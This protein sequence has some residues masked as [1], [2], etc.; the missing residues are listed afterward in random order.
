MDELVQKIGK[1]LQKNPDS[2]ARHICRQI[3]VDKKIVNRCLYA[4]RKIHFLQ[5]G[6]APPLWRNIDDSFKTNSD[7]VTKKIKQNASNTTR[8]RQN[9]HL[10][11]YPSPLFAQP[12]EVGKLFGYADRTGEYLL[13]GPFSI[14]D[15]ET[16]GL[17]PSAGKIL[18]I[19]IRKVD[20]D[21]REIEQFETLI[22]PGDGNVGR[23]D[24]H[25]IDLR[26]LDGAPYFEDVVGRIF[27][28]IQDSVVVAHH[29][30]FEEN[31][32]FSE[33][34]DS[35]Y[36]LEPIPAL[37]TLW[38]AR[39]LT[40]LSDYKLK[41][42][43]K[44]FGKRFDNPHTA[45]GDVLAVSEVLPEMLSRIGGLYFPV[46]HSRLPDASTPFKAKTR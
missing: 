7:F 4:N 27:E 28:V 12:G 16:S 20:L 14:I 18:E 24:I 8:Y 6:L 25:G 36:D 21:G 44:A 9:N 29:A 41:S 34:T 11:T 22:N 38:L 46:K 1:Y 33:L 26:M 17:S 35:G 32:L 30:R 39:K 10:K 15:L 43:V 45:L 13:G 31:F 2:K 23:T 19:A 37:D 40:N 5:T 42:V 3:G